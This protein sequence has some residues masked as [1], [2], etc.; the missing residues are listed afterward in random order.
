M[1]LSILEKAEEYHTLIGDYVPKEGGDRMRRFV[2]AV[3][4]VFTLSVPALGRA[5]VWEIDPAHSSAQ[6]AVRHLMVSNVRGTFSKVS[7]TVTLDESD[8]TKSSIEATIDTASINTR[9]AKRDDH[10]KG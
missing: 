4:I 6:F 7:G 5:S 8:P 2:F 1:T 10:L 9:I 3:F